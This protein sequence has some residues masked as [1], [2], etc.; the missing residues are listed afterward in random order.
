VYPAIPSLIQRCT[1]TA[2]LGRL[3]S[4]FLHPV[5]Q[6]PATVQPFPFMSCHGA[7]RPRI[8]GP[9]SAHQDW[10]LVD[11]GWLKLAS[12]KL[13]QTSGRRSRYE[14]GGA[15]SRPSRR[16]CYFRHRA[17]DAPWIPLVPGQTDHKPLVM[18][19]TYLKPARSCRQ[20]TRPVASP[21]SS[22]SNSATPLTI[23]ILTWIFPSY[24]PE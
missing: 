5:L 19:G 14:P 11:D 17:V 3:Q 6:L 16:P 20:A 13:I 10:F 21:Y 12:P 22:V 18:S 7:L 2:H 24:D 4:L 8:L 23:D 1:L 15:S 9:P